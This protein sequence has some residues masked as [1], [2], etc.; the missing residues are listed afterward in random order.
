MKT[1]RPPNMF[2]PIVGLIYDV[3]PMP[4]AVVLSAIFAVAIS[5]FA[6]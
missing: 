1:V 6:R 2:D 3:G 5:R 4:I